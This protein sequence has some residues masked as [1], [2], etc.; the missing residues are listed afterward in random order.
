MHC[1]GANSRGIT[2]PRDKKKITSSALKRFFNL[3]LKIKG[4]IR[5]EE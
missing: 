4:D 2:I 1:V 3:E 5:F